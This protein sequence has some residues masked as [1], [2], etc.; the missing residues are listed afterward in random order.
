M[1]MARCNCSTVATWMAGGRTNSSDHLQT[2]V[3]GKP[4]ADCTDPQNRHKKGSILLQM[5]HL[6]GKVEFRKIA[7]RRIKK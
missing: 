1:M 3:N 6:T 4:G 5:H 2:W 7:I